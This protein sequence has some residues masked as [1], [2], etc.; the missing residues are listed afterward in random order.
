MIN[1]RMYDAN[2]LLRRLRLYNVRYD[3]DACL[4]TLLK[5]IAILQCT[6]P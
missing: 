4:L 1:N 3:Y 2:R 6:S 5:R